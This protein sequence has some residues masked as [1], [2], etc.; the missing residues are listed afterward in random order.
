MDPHTSLETVVKLEKVRSEGERGQAVDGSGWIGS[1]DG[2]AGCSPGVFKAA[3]GVSRVQ[4]DPA[5]PERGEG[6]VREA[7]GNRPVDAVCRV[8]G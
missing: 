7:V 3:G 5:P 8:E 4:A 6:R 1:G 2:E